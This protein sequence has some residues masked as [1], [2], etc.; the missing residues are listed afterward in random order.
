VRSWE[1]AT[2][3]FF[4]YIALVALVLRGIER[5]VR[6]RVLGGAFLGV[7]L[8]F[9]A[10]ALPLGSF[11][12]VWVLPP[13]LLACAYWTSGG[14]FV[15]PMPRV[16]YLLTHVDTAL[17][18]D[19]IA[20]RMPRAAAEA[21][22]CAYSSVYA[23]IPIALYL[24]P[25]SGVSGERFWQVVLATDYIC[26]G[27]L[28]WIQTRPP[29]AFR[30]GEPWRSTWRAVNIRMLDASSIQVNTFPSGHAAEALAAALLVWGAPAPIVV[31]MSIAAVAIAAG[32]V[33]GRYHYAVDALAGWIVAVVVYCVTSA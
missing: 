21:L 4:A 26:F 2:A 24:A 23:V 14:L 29:R 20:A 8:D 19:R 16:E 17:R 15:A 13:L 33:L 18:I 22:E 12:R 25:R 7:A 32:A 3:L 10:L 31:T 6:L 30:L 28:P 27:C 1:L 11:A 5:G 9:G